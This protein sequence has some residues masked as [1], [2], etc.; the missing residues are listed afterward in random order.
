[1]QEYTYPGVSREVCRDLRALSQ[2]ADVALP[3]LERVRV[4]KD[5][6][7]VLRQAKEAI[8]GIGERGRD[9]EGKGERGC[10]KE[11]GGGRARCAGYGSEIGGGWVE[12]ELTRMRRE[13]ESMR[14]E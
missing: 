10:V 9:A 6:E 14:R 7:D 4:I 12:R 1:M 2:V 5:G 11:Q 8:R 3:V 13:L